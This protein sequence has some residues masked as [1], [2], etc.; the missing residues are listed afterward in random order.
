MD[1]PSFTPRSILVIRRDNIGDLL[2]TT[3]AISALRS[4][5]PDA[6]LCILVNSYN[7]PVLANNPDLDQIF[8]YT[9]AKHSS[10]SR[11]LAWL[12]QLW[13]YL[14]LRR[15]NFDLVI[16]ANPSPHR[17]TEKL[18]RFLQPRASIGTVE[19]LDVHSPWTMPI[20]SAT[21]GSGHHVE[22]VFALLK[23]LGIA[24]TP[25]L[26]SLTCNTPSQGYTG[27]HLSSRKPCNRWPAAHYIELARKLINQGHRLRLFWAPGSQDNRLH[28]GDDE[29]AQMVFD[30]LADLP[31]TAVELRPTHSLAELMEELAACQ[32]VI[33]PDGGALHIAAALPRPCIALFGCTDPVQWGPW[34]EG[35]KVLV[36]DGQASEITVDQ[37]AAAALAPPDP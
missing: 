10:G 20:S 16:H 12:R 9:K 19:S 4:R 37:V 33:A 23:P 5:Y 29:L 11:L 6:R 7:A 14:K 18:V 30:G 1:A 15:I 22:R 21:L 26:M 31:K 25:G 3:P 17:R 24:G 34:G 8:V 27:I 28:P 2:C 36:G 13:L 35:H 32:S